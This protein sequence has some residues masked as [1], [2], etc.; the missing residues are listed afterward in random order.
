MAN[1]IAENAVLAD[2]LSESPSSNIAAEGGGQESD[3]NNTATTQNNSN[4]INLEDTYNV[5]APEESV[6]VSLPNSNGRIININA[7][8]TNTPDNFVQSSMPDSEKAMKNRSTGKVNAPDDSAE[9]SMTGS[10]VG[11]ENTNASAQMLSPDSNGGE[12]DINVGHLSTL[13]PSA[14]LS[15]P[16]SNDQRLNISMIKTQHLNLNKKYEDL[17]NT[18]EKYSQKSMP[19]LKKVVNTSN[20]EESTTPNPH[21][22]LSTTNIIRAR[23]SISAEN[24]NEPTEPTQISNPDSTFPVV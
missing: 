17:M 24:I 11:I 19:N 3:N 7:R 5:D 20:R 13:K 21:L 6:R 23:Q 10:N 1:T 16:D 18:A 2:I 9:I 8:K 12:K 4:T 14:Q 15:M 22:Q